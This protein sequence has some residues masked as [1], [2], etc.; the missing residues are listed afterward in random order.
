MSRLTLRSLRVSLGGRRVV[1]G[2][3]LAARAG[4]VLGLLGPNGAGKSTALRAALGLLPFEGEILFDGVPLSRLA[5]RERARRA[6]YLPQEREIAWRLS[7]EALVGLG[8][9]P[10][11]VS[12]RDAEAVAAALA[13]TGLA[14]LGH[15]PAAE[16]SGG[17]RARALFARALAQETPLLLADEPAAGLDPAH[18]LDLMRTLRGFAEAG[19]AAIV[20]L[21]DLSLA[22]RGCDRL[23]V[24]DQ[25]RLAAEG[26]PGEVLTPELLAQVY[27]VR[28]R[29]DRVEGAPSVVVLGRA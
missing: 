27:G 13:R 24:L 2:L 28:A 3:D 7:V 11:P 8:R 5:P 6:A 12:P 22:A 4:E 14:A 29:V 9:A 21:H 26:A 1:D 25:G 15:R 23:A 16:L 17:E 10:W 18:Q 19:G 20:T